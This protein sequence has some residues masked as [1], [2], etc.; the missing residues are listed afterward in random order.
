MNGPLL[1]FDDRV[2]VITGAGRGI[3]RAHAHAFAQRG[4][5]VVVN[6]VDTAADGTPS[7]P[8]GSVA[9]QVAE[10]IRHAGGRA[11]ADTGDV[12]IEAEAKT[13]IDRARWVFGR[14]DIV[15]NNAGIDQA[16][17]LED[18]TAALLKHFFAVHVLGSFHVASA[19]WPHLREQGYGRVLF[20]TSSAGYFGLGE[21]L[22]YATAKGALHAMAQSLSIE[23]APHGITVNA[24]S[25]FADSRLAQ[26]RTANRPA[27]LDLI[28]RY[29]PASAVAPVALWLC[30]ESTALTGCAFETGGG[31]VCR[32]F[33]GQAP[34]ISIAGLTP[35]DLRDHESQL[36]DTAVFTVPPAGGRGRPMLDQLT[37][38]SR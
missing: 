20:T 21:A 13:L 14:V 11:I 1:R 30:H 37:H 22:P 17:Q 9:E 18:V 25:P 6:D 19:A 16:V 8:G 15:I 28:E 36:L 4:A 12:S 26:S 2:V 5:A 34:G 35:E 29:A 27:F 38:I 31:I 3:G 24:I 7:A 23:G 32:T 33:A 10:E